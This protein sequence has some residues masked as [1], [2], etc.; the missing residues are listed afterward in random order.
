[1]W[2]FNEV[3]DIKYRG[4][5]VYSIRFDDGV[6][7]EVDFSEYFSKGPVFQRLKDKKVFS[8]AH[9]EGGTIAWPNGTDVA[10]ES[11]YEKILDAHKS[12]QRTRKKAA[13][14]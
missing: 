8:K 4:E 9:V 13:R 10:P 6:E 14:R 5:Y 11:L 3:T 7:G 2:D 12:L 1:M